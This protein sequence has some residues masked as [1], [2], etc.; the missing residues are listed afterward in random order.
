MLSKK[1]IFTQIKHPIV[2]LGFA[3]ALL[4]VLQDASIRV[5]KSTP[6]AKIQTITDIQNS[7]INLSLKGEQ[8]ADIL[9]L[10]EIYKPSLEIKKEEKPI[11]LT[12]EEQ[13]KQ[14]GV[15]T[16]VFINNNKLILK[17][18]IQP[19]DAQKRVALISVLN[20]DSN[21]MKLQRFD[22]ETLVFGFE[23]QVLNNTQVK[24]TANREL[25]KQEIILSMFKNIEPSN[26]SQ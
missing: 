7:A 4:W 26:E 18:I 19:N 9:S 22:D 8:V 13:A 24:L 15:L 11:G 20:T 2:I 17:A 1:N 21:E 5:L 25:Q 3:I 23:L 14:S 16:E 12:K 6:D 10:F